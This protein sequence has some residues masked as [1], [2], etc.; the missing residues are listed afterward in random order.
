VYE[1]RSGRV[2]EQLRD[3]GRA[4]AFLKGYKREVPGDPWALEKLQQFSAVG[5]E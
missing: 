1:A 4:Q 2:D 5:F 3:P